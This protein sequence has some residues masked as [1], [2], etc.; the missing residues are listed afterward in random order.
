MAKV[1]R[2]KNKLVSIDILHERNHLAK[3]LEE[4]HVRIE[5][6]NLRVAELIDEIADHENQKDMLKTIIID[7]L[8]RP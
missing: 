2:P 8:Q 4:A 3:R 5:N 6:L 7:A 1:G